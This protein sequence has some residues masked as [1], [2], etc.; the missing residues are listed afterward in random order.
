MSKRLSRGPQGKAK[1]GASK[2]NL[3]KIPDPG[4][5]PLIEHIQERTEGAAIWIAVCMC[6]QGEALERCPGERQLSPGTQVRVVEFTDT[7]AIVARDGEK[8]GY[9]PAAALAPLQ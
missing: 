7:S 2:L 6:D 8:L 3:E 1:G 9:V 4:S 5:A